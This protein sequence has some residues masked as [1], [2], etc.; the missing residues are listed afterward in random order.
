MAISVKLL[1]LSVRTQLKISARRVLGSFKRPVSKSV[2]IAFFEPL[3]VDNDY[4][5]QALGSKHFR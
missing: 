2:A 5:E 4:G 3:G 1:S